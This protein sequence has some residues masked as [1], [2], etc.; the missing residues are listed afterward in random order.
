MRIKAVLLGSDCAMYFCEPNLALSTGVRG[1]KSI[2]PSNSVLVAAD[3]DL[4]Y[5][6]SLTPSVYMVVKFRTQLKSFTVEKL[7][8]MRHAS[9]MV[10]SLEEQPS[11]ILKFSDGGTDHR[12]T[13]ESVK[14]SAIGLF[15]ELDL[16][17]YIAAMCA[18]GHSWTNPADRM[19]SLLNIGLQ[20]CADRNVLK[21]LSC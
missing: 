5:K 4:H 6:G 15:K 21:I 20:N 3:H 11:V 2:A 9:A 7:T 19:M 14:C 10:K 16:N 17:I 18:P 12:N 13:L 1:K 8:S